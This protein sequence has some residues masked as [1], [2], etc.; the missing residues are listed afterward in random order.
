MTIIGLWFSMSVIC[1]LLFGAFAVVGRGDDVKPL[2]IWVCE[3]IVKGLKWV[4]SLQVRLENKVYTYKVRTYGVTPINSSSHE[5][6]EMKKVVETLSKER[7]RSPRSHAL[8]ETIKKGR[9]KFSEEARKSFERKIGASQKL[10]DEY[11]AILKG[12]E[13]K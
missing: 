6:D 9:V 5:N 10:F 8:D 2:D 1:G 3:L 7:G 11:M 13:V 12:K 4:T